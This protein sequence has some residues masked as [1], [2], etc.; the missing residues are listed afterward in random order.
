MDCAQCGLQS[1]QVVPYFC[2]VPDIKSTT[3]GPSTLMFGSQR[4]TYQRETDYHGMHSPCTLIWCM[5]SCS[6]LAHPLSLHLHSL[7]TGDLSS[8][9]MSKFFTSS[10]LMSPP[11]PK[12]PRQRLEALPPASILSTCACL[13]AALSTSLTRRRRPAT[14]TPP[15]SLAGAP[16]QLLAFAPQ[17]SLPR[18]PASG[19][20]I[21]CSYPHSI[22]RCPRT[23][24]ASPPVT[25][26]VLSSRWR[27]QRVFCH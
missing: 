8:T 13:A 6:Q 2:G 27:S 10:S 20:S 21:T 5:L 7:L 26:R 1:S 12:R 9:E 4:T 22:P 11:A 18:Y 25:D 24:Q 16:L 3:A 23:S 17:R 19:L 15:P 14:T